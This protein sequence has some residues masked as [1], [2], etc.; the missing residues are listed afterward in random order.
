MSSTGQP[1]H[2]G[3]D[4]RRLWAAY[5]VSEFGT[6]VGTC[7][8]PLLA[9]MVLDAPW[10]VTLQAA[11]SAVA[12][13]VGLPLGVRM[14]PGPKR[15]Y[16]IGADVLRFVPLASLLAATVL[17]VVF[18]RAHR[19]TPVGTE[20]EPV[21]R[22]PHGHTGRRGSPRQPATAMPANL[23]AATLAAPTASGLPNVN[24]LPG[25][26]G[27]CRIPDVTAWP[28]RRSLVLP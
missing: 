27:S 14:D 5:A 15:P 2:L 9:I 18:A 28:T 3:G 10:Q 23:S 8:L 16:L 17:G 19:V 21:V 20:N 7:A 22:P 13:A 25:I 4:F 12:A 24:L 6:A 1:Q 11:L 26:S